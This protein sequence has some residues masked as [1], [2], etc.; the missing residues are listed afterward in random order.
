MLRSKIHIIK[1]YFKDEHQRDDKV[2]VPL[3]K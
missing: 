1:G 2:T 3:N